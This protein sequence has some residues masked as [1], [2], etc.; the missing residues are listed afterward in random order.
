MTAECAAL[1][2]ESGWTT[3][4]RSMNWKALLSVDTAPAGTA[5]P[6]ISTQLAALPGPF[7]NT[8]GQLIAA[9]A[10]SFWGPHKF[11]IETDENGAYIGSGAQVWTGSLADGKVSPT[12]TCAS[13][14]A[15]T[16]VGRV[17]NASGLNTWFDQ[18]TA[19]MPCGSALR[20]YCLGYPR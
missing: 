20:V 1:A 5:S 7:Y 19:T 2:Y 4:T 11:P 13:W 12:Q 15:K 16:G 3:H 10:A 8:G 18:G 14:T 6:N 9:D 17:G